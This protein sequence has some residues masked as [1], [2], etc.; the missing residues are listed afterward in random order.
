MVSLSSSFPC[1]RQLW[2]FCQNWE[3]IFDW[4]E[5]FNHCCWLKT[6]FLTSQALATSESMEKVFVCVSVELI[7]KPTDQTRHIKGKK[8]RHEWSNPAL[9]SLNAAKQSRQPST[10]GHYYHPETAA[11]YTWVLPPKLREKEEGMGGWLFREGVGRE[12][13]LWW[14]HDQ[15]LHYSCSDTLRG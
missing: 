6:V 2:T 8:E 11:V 7:D 12:G 15:L 4:T 13:G 14:L 3:T 10:R 9:Q 5:G 1:P